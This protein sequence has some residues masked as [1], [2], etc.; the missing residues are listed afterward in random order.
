MRGAVDEAST[1]EYQSYA[2][3]LEAPLSQRAGAF[4]RAT[5]LDEASVSVANSL[6]AH[7]SRLCV[8][9]SAPATTQKEHHP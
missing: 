4:L 3:K 1:K 9:R 5:Y 2:F 7:S 8:T 6:K